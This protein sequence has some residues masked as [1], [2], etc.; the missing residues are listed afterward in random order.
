MRR[1]LSGKGPEALAELV[2]S[3]GSEAFRGKQLFEAIQTHGLHELGSATTLPR[4]LRDALEGQEYRVHELTVDVH[5]QSLD[6]TVKLGLGTSDGLMV[7]TVLIPM[8]DGSF[9]QCLSSQAGCA[10]GCRFCMTAT[11]GLAR[12]LTPSEILDQHLL[13]LDRSG[14]GRIKNL[15]FMGMGEPLMNFDSVKE[16][17]EVLQHPRGRG[18]SHRRVT[19]STSGVIPGIERVGSEMSVLLAVSLNAPN[20]SIRSQLMPIS[21][22]YPLEDLMEALRRY[23]LGERQRLT[24]EY[25][26]IPGVND[27]DENARELVRLISHLRCKVNVIPFNPFPGAAFG[28]P[29]EAEIERFSGI[30]S[31][32][33]VRVT[34]RRSRGGDIDAACG[35]LAGKSECTWDAEPD[36][37]DP[38]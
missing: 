27:S 17:V 16:A 14:G 10:M 5:Q 33:S 13:A 31:G 21:K 2:K 22:R 12:N 35:Q 38:D 4:K 36:E 18:Y 6:G 30:L 1:G 23:P 15:V 25:V 8:P 20:Q 32:K 9:T 24:L 29:S 28:A 7:E 11:L 37:P 34:V 19:I 3:L 26:L